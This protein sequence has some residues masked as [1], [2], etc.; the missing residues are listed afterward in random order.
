MDEYKSKINRRMT[1][2]AVCS[3]LIVILYLS[4]KQ[5]IEAPN[6][7]G[8]VTGLCIALEVLILGYLTKLFFSSRS[9]NGLKKLAVS[10]G[11]ERKALILQ[12]TSR[13]G[14]VIYAVGLGLATVVASFINETVFMTLMG[15]LTFMA[16]IKIILRVYFQRKY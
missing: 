6:Q 2:M 12:K 7:I 15:V 3:V 13:V 9:E 11:D 4:A 16:L 14:I 5:V 1:F 8:F 10:E